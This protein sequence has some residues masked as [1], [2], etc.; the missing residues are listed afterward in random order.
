MAKKKICIDI[1][2]ETFHELLNAEKTLGISP[3]T[4]ILKCLN[5]YLRSY[6]EVI[7]ELRGKHVYVPVVIK[8]TRSAL[9]D[10][11]RKLSS[12]GKTLDDWVEEIVWRELLKIVTGKK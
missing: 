11:L 12:R 2:Y 6:R 4:F 8:I 5:D 7:L 3:K 1:D 10:L 9:I